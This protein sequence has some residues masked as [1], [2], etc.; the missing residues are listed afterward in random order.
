MI[1]RLQVEGRMVV[2]HLSAILVYV[3]DINIAKHVDIDGVRADTGYFPPYLQAVEKARRMQRTLELA[4]QALYDDAATL[5]A[6]VQAPL[7]SDVINDTPNTRYDYVD[8]LAR[9]VLTNLESVTSALE[10][11]WMLGQNQ[12]ELAETVYSNSIEWRQSRGSVFFQPSEV[13]PPNG[14]AQQA[15]ED[16]VDMEH[17][18]SRQG[19]FRTMSSLDSHGTVANIYHGDAGH[20]SETSLNMSDRTRSDGNGEPLTPTWPPHESSEAGT[21]VA[22]A[23]SHDYDADLLEED[24]E[25]YDE[26]GRAYLFIPSKVSVLNNIVASNSKTPGRAHKL[27]KLLGEAPQHYINKVNADAQPW[28]LRPNYDQS[29]ILI[30]ADGSVRAG[31]KQALVERLTPHETAGEHEGFTSHLWHSVANL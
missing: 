15:E 12:S 2:A 1:D 11:L 27:I 30:E 17:A 10:S 16:V 3:C 22:S 19:A 9:T 6:A 20:A 5:L 7:S 14:V 29:E 31:S 23:S 21:L 28:Y 26:A 8:L 25:L 18:F 24:E 4:V 13:P